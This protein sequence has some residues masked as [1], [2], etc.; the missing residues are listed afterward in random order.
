MPPELDTFL[1]S[2]SKSG[3]RMNDKHLFVDHAMKRSLQK[4]FTLIE[5][6]IV[7]AIIGILAA[8]ALPAYLDYRTCAPSC[9]RA[10][11]VPFFVEERHRRRLHVG[12]NGRGLGRGPLRQCAAQQLQV[13]SSITAVD[14]T[15][16]LIITFIAATTGLPARHAGVHPGHPDG[17]RCGSAAG[18]CTDGCDRLGLLERG[19]GQGARHGDRADRRHRAR[20]LRAE[21]VSLTGMAM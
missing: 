21:R 8:V 11:S 13:G 12:R 10:W 5:L 16:E 7:V 4:G 6:M 20:P 17:R 15:G 3:A 1:I 2:R 19:P 14:V 9:R 18:R